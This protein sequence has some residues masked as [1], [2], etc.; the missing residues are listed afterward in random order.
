MEAADD[1]SHLLFFSVSTTAG[2]RFMLLQYSPIPP[3]SGLESGSK[4]FCLALYS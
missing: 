3:S 2:H 1:H 4:K